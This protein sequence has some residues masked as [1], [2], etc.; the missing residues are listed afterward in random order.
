MTIKLNINYLNFGVM[1]FEHVY[2]L[3][4][5]KTKEDKVKISKKINYLEEFLGISLFRKF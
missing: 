4:Y 1:R 3:A 2:V 5:E